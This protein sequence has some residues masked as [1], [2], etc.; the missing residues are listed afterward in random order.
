MDLVRSLLHE[1][2][3]MSAFEHPNILSLTGVCLDG[4]PIPYVVMPFMFNGDLL[5][6]LKKERSSLVMPLD[7]EVG[8]NN[9][10][11]HQS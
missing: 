3:K 2:V 11:R 9:V 6:Y 10:V 8:E 7:T 5:S 4:G 1:C